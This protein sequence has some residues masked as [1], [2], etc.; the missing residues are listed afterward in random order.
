MLLLSHRILCWRS[1]RGVVY[2]IY[3]QHGR[4]SRRSFAIATSR[5]YEDAV[6]L[7]NTLQTPFGVLKQRRDAGIGLDESAKVEMRKCLHQIGYSQR[8]LDK[9]NVIHVAGTKGK[10]S[11]CALVGSILS[12]YRQSRAMP[13]NVGLFTSPH[14]IAVRERI[15]INSIPISKGLFAKYFFEVWD[16]LDAASATSSDLPSP[17]PVYFRYLTLMSYHVFLQEG[18]DAAIYEV[19]MGGEFDS[20]NIVDHPAV[21][22]ISTLGIDHVAVLGKTIEE[23]AWHKAGIQKAGVPSFTV[24][25]TPAAL[26]V[27]RERAEERHVGSLAVLEEDPR[28]RKV[29][30]RP[31][32]PFQRL[33]ATLAV[34]LAETALRKLDSTFEIPPGALPEEFVN[35]LENAV[36][37]G[38]CEVKIEGNITWYLDGAHTQDSIAIAAKWFGDESFKKTG[39]RVLIFNQQGDRAAMELLEGLFQAIAS[40]GSASFDHVIFCPTVPVDKVGKR[41]SIIHPTDSAAM[42]G[43][44]TQKAFARRWM[45]LDISSSTMIKVLPSIEDAVEYVRSLEKQDDDKVHAFITGSVHLVGRALGILEGVEAL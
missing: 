12:K 45:E 6:D 38:R 31:N 7:L 9:L 18:V 20:T 4:S 11:T 15:R 30:V 24:K 37:R 32:A 10:G 22:G 43:L 28:L 26:K 44:E 1:K 21:T 41:D 25:Q 5:T 36:W 39:I 17:K 3:R 35:G 34:A 16:K 19:G 23:I 33:N 14:L 8:D 13:R 2:D 29:R 27:I 40:Q 42:A